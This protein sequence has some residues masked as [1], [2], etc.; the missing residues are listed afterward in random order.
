VPSID[1]LPKNL[2]DVMIL[3]QSSNSVRSTVVGSR[4]TTPI[5]VHHLMIEV[6]TLWQRTNV[7]QNH[8]MLAEQFVTGLTG[9]Q[10]NAH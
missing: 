8:T 10:V 5:G 1:V 6:M 2:N 3:W 7:G 4:T 9:S